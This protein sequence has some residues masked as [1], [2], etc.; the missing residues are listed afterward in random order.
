MDVVS[1]HIHERISTKAILDAVRR[2]EPAQPD[3]FSWTP[4]LVDQEVE[5]Y[6]HE[7]NTA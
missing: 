3:G 7:V 5:F 1:L 6:R 2:P 4:L